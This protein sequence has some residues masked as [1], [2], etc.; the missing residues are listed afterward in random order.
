MRH[1]PCSPGALLTVAV[2][3]WGASTASAAPTL[4]GVYP[5]S[6]APAQATTSPDGTAWFILSGSSNGKEL[7]GVTPAGVVTEYDV[8][9]S[10][11]ED[12]VAVNAGGGPRLWFSGSSNGSPGLIE[13]DPATQ[14]TTPHS[15]AGLSA[16]RGITYSTSFTTGQVS[17][18]IGDGGGAG[19]F[20]VTATGAK[21]S[22]TPNPV[23]D[24]V[25]TTPPT[26]VGNM[27]G[28]ATGVDGKIWWADF[29]NGAIRSMSTFQSS[30]QVTS[31]AVGGGPQEVLA[32][33]PG[34]IAFTSPPGTVGRIRGATVIPVNVPGTDPFGIAYGNDGAYYFAQFAASKLLRMASDGALSDV[35][36]PG[37]P[38]Y[39]TSSV[40]GKTLFVGLENTHQIARIVGVEPPPAS[41]TPQGP[42]TTGQQPSGNTQLVTDLAAPVLSGLTMT[43]RRFKV[44]KGATAIS[45]ATKIGTTF[46]FSVT[47]AGTASLVIARADKGR[48]K[49]KSCVKPTAKLKKAAKCT[50]Y[51]KVGTLKRKTTVGVNRVAFTGRIGTKALKAAKYRLTVTAV[52]AAGNKS[53]ASRTTFTVVKK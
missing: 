47:E 31:V 52:D 44:G 27:R 8:N 51:V 41:T 24:D 20:E 14:T 23:V 40:D 7:A 3:L 10:A 5:L 17:F 34:E 26:V 1:W 28:L 46:R 37:Q 25:G 53:G 15:V 11:L 36:L 45:A 29:S 42:P 2:L 19:L 33:R 43:N 18:W 38:R 30:A 32:G 48:K 16:P 6:G 12:V 22:R 13:F 39:L 50:R 21:T 9:A 49:G 35:P 4:D